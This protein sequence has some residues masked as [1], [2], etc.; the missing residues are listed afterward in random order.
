MVCWSDNLNWKRILDKLGIFL[1]EEEKSEAIWNLQD[2]MGHDYL[3]S[4]DDEALEKLIIDY[5]IKM[6]NLNGRKR[7]RKK[8]K[9]KKEEE[10]I[11]FYT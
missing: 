2:E 11:E 6:K 3:K 8:K 5:I 4:L 9:S 10:Y 1:S 7:R